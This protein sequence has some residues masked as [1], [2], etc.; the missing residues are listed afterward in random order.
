[1][2]DSDVM[3]N[4][5]AARL[6]ATPEQDLEVLEVLLDV[7]EAASCLM[8]DEQEK[9][10]EEQT[11]VQQTRSEVLAFHAEFRD[12][13]QSKS[14]GGGAPKGKTCSCFALRHGAV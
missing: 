12:M 5:L 9:L 8:W 4:C 13:R 2:S 3:L 11:R 6:E 7:D 10:S 14:G 1:M